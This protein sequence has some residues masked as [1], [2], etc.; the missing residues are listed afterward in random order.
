MEDGGSSGARSNAQWRIAERSHEICAA[1][2]FRAQA[3]P[4]ASGLRTQAFW[5]TPNLEKFPNLENISVFLPEQGRISAARDCRRRMSGGTGLV[6]GAPNA[7]DCDRE[8]L[9]KEGWNTNSHESS[10]IDSRSAANAS[11]PCGGNAFRVH[12]I[13]GRRPRDSS[14]VTRAQR[15]EFSRIRLPGMNNSS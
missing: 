13:D 14:G 3:L 7:S 9:R 8:A 5:C 12:S 15:S 6:G 10:P 1:A 2:G 11:D 4:Q